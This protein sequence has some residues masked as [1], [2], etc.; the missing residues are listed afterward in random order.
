MNVDY[1]DWH[2]DSNLYYL[3]GILD[4]NI[5]SDKL[6]SKERSVGEKYNYTPFRLNVGTLLPAGHTMLLYDVR[7]KICNVFQ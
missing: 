3:I 1:A 6:D 4:M 7:N 2:L 5:E